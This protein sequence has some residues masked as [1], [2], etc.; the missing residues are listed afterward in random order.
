MK[1]NR[2][3]FQVSFTEK[4]YRQIM[5]LLLQMKQYT[6]MTRS[7]LVKRMIADYG[8]RKA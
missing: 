3:V 8:S 1:L 2:Y 5:P 7:N 6:G 4:E